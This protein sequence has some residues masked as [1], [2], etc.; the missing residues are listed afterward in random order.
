[1]DIVGSLLLL[2]AESLPFSL[3]TLTDIIIN[4]ARVREL[5]TKSRADSTDH[6]CVTH[7]VKSQQQQFTV[8][9][10]PSPPPSSPPP[11]S[12]QHA[13]RR[14]NLSFQDSHILFEE[15]AQPIIDSGA[16]HD[17]PP[18]MSWAG[19]NDTTAAPEEEEENDFGD[20]TMFS[21]LCLRPFGT[22]YSNRE[23]CHGSFDFLNISAITRQNDGDVTMLTP[24]SD[25]HRGKPKS[26]PAITV[27]VALK[28]FV[29]RGSS[30]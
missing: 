3:M 14:D 5:L 1:M 29:E 27:Y 30:F 22:M 23:A 25:Y 8:V 28:V 4:E 11:P 19:L 18:A 16:T 17:D 24:E 7:G 10:S 26:K 20:E 15:S 21:P 12:S 2:P 6:A 9:A 13:C